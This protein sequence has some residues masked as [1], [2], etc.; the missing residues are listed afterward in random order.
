[1]FRRRNYFSAL[2]GVALICPTEFPMETAALTRRTRCV[3]QRLAFGPE[4]VPLPI[5]FFQLFQR[6]LFGRARIA[7]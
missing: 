3:S 6:F 2:F 5:Q 4:F 1:M 7:G